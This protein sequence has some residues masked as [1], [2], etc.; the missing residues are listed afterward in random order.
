MHD[1]QKANITDTR[2]TGIGEAYYNVMRKSLCVCVLCG[3]FEFK[4]N[5]TQRAETVIFHQKEL[6]L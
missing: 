3:N 2:V 1:L 4:E 6:A 5:G